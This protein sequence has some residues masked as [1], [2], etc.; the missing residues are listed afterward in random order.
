[1]LKKNEYFQEYVEGE[2]ISVQFIS[3]KNELK[4]ISICEQVL[5]KDTFYIDH[6]ISKK[7]NVKAKKKNFQ[8]VKKNS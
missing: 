8:F 2:N 4:L 1:M 7:L 3:N 6:L 5:R